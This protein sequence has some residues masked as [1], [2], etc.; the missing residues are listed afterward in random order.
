MYRDFLYT[1]IVVAVLTVLGVVIQVLL[2]GIN[3]LD[4]IWYLQQGFTIYWG[5]IQYLLILTIVFIW[6]PSTN[7][8][9]MSY[10]ELIDEPDEGIV[11][12][13]LPQGDAI[14]RHTNINQIVEPKDRAQDVVQLTITDFAMD[15]LDEDMVGAK[16]D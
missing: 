5:S 10:S 1:L 13:P 6:R 12:T 14:Q 16:K 2:T 3:G 4:K 15:L 9:L 11:L 7:N 8:A